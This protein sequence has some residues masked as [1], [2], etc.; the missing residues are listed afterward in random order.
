MRPGPSAPILVPPTHPCRLLGTTLPLRAVPSIPV[1]LGPQAV[2]RAGG[3][4]SSRVSI[5]SPEAFAVTDSET[6]R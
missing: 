2:Q 1:L 3:T 5:L 6:S 4:H